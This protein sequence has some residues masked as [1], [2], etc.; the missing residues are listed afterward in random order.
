MPAQYLHETQ[1]DSNHR[2]LELLHR[3]NIYPD[4]IVAIAFY[5]AL[6]SLERYFARRNQHPNDHID[7]KAI[8]LSFESQLSRQVIRDYLDM[9]NQSVIARYECVLP[10][11]KDV[12]DQMSRLARIDAVVGP[13]V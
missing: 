12:R 7:R 10:S 3:R 6:H 8:L 4:W 11:S 5:T 9:Y 2:L 13:L 1:W